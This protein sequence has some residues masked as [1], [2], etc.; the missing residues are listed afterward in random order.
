V[1]GREHPGKPDKPL[2]YMVNPAA[3]HGKDTLD[4][5]ASALSEVDDEIRPTDEAPAT[6]NLTAVDIGDLTAYCSNTSTEPARTMLQL[7]RDWYEFCDHTRYNDCLARVA[8]AIAQQIT[9][10]D[11]D[12]CSALLQSRSPASAAAC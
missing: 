12:V 8:A 5:D 9:I 4:S 2:R 11:Q 6:H 3:T 7:A 10:A 1:V